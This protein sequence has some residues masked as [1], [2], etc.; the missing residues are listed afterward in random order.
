MAAGLNQIP[1]RCSQPGRQ[2][3]HF[4]MKTKFSRHTPKD[5]LNELQ[6]LVAEAESMMSNSLSEHSAEAFSA[7]RKRFGETRERFS[8]AYDGTKKKVLDGVESTEATIRANPYQSVAIA[9]G[10]G[11]IAGVLLGR[12]NR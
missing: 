2:T 3:S 12:R 5:L 11:L 9:A 6:A 1:A 7:L 10:V 4:K 8:E